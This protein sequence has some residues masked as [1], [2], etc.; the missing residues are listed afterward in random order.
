MSENAENVVARSSSKV[1]IEE[2]ARR[3]VPQISVVGIGGAGCNI[4]SWMKGKGVSGARIYALNSDAQHLSITKAD[5]RLLIGYKITGGLGCG[6]FPE[7][8]AKAAEEAA[9]DIEKAIEDS[10][11]I[12]AK[13]NNEI[14]ERFRNYF[15]KI[16]ENF[17]D[18]FSKIF[19]GGSGDLVL[20]NEDDLL[21]TGIDIKANPPGKRILSKSQL[22]GGEVALSAIAFLFSFFLLKPSPICIL[23]EA[24]A[25]LDDAN[26]LR[27]VNLVKEFS[28]KTQFIVITHNKRTMEIGDVLYGITMEEPGVSK[29]LSVELR[30][31]QEVV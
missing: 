16:R 24:D 13:I 29:V 2:I 15:D 6:G 23:D 10:R 27:F 11:K 4:V 21:S 8:G 30:K 18:L 3:A 1:S 22:S 26:I 9:E 5:E 14:R 25:P 12:I 28:K 7:Q 31:V 17:R 20:T 19:E